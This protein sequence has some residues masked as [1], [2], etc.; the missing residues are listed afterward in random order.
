MAVMGLRRLLARD[1]RE[2][3]TFPMAKFCPMLAKPLPCHEIRSWQASF[4]RKSN[5]DD[6]KDN[7]Q[8]EVSWINNFPCAFFFSVGPSSS[9]T[10]ALSDLHPGRMHT[11]PRL[12]ASGKGGG[13]PL[14]TF[15]PRSH[16]L[17]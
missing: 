16:C 6:T 11:D 8:T 14:L 10:R 9:F 4:K 3:L 7:V 15:D 1:A 12:E 2:H 5:S 13:D 17:I